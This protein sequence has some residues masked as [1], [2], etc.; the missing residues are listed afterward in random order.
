MAGRSRPMDARA[1]QHRE[2]TTIALREKAPVSRPGLRAQTHGPHALSMASDAVGRGPRGARPGWHDRSYP[3]A[4]RA[5]RVNIVSVA[6][7]DRAATVAGHP[8]DGP[9]TPMA[10][11][12]SRGHRRR[13][14][15]RGAFELD[16]EALEPIERRNARPNSPGSPHRL[17]MT[18][19]GARGRRVRAPWLL[20][21]CSAPARPI[22]HFDRAFSPDIPA[23]HATGG[24]PGRGRTEIDLESLRGGC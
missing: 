22:S 10:R 19:Q 13:H 11:R 20:P 1:Q 18:W 7:P 16:G 23:A 12:R 6:A 9:D 3:R 8:R 14:D 24:S 21:P 4:P 2:P 15:D 5:G 17:G